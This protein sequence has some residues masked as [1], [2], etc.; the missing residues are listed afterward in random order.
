MK[1]GIKFYFAFYLAKASVLALKIIRRDATQFPGKL[2]ITLCPEN[3]KFGQR[4][5]SMLF[6]QLI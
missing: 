1:K 5:P 4:L 6:Y 3:R 2:A